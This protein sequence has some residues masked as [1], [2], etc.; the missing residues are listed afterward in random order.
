MGRRLAVVLVLLGAVGAATAGTLAA[1]PGGSDAITTLA[2]HTRPSTYQLGSDAGGAATVLWT[3]ENWVGADNRL[4]AVIRVRQQNGQGGWGRAVRIGGITQTIDAKLVVS[5]SGA[6]TVVWDY[7]RSGAHSQT[8][9][10]A[11]TRSTA[12]GAWSQP[13]MIWSTANVNGLSMVVSS[14]ADGTATVAWTAYHGINPAILAATVD[15]ADG[16]TGRLERVVAAG[17][18]G[19]DLGLAEN[20]AGAAVISWQCQLSRPGRRT[21]G[22]RSRFG[23]MAA[24]RAATGSSW[25]AAQRLGTFSVPE[26]PASSIV[27]TPSS[28]SSVVTASGT[29]AVGWRVGVGGSREPLQVSTHTAGGSHWTTPH[30]LTT[31][32]GG[33][34]LAAGADN[35]LVAVWSTDPA[36]E[37]LLLTVTSTDAIHWST[38][39]RLPSVDRGT[40]G[41]ILAAAADG[42]IALTPLTG[43]HT[44]I[45]YTTRSPAGHWSALKRIGTG[46]LSEIAVASSGSVTVLWE[47]FNRRGHYRLRVYTQL[48]H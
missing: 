12:T 41:P 2:S 13:K 18:G 42:R 37:R 17:A 31:N 27:W 38:P 32:L 14:A 36:T 15:A 24:Q 48:P 20:A 9:L 29:A 21:I 45:R 22:S 3:T 28:P 40:F 4:A 43:N 5:A 1:A 8:V 46:D 35:T 10:M 33:F 26:E 39:S 44:P 6:A 23:E 11:A 34:G 30:T 47:T 25:S 19:T 16:A 7:V